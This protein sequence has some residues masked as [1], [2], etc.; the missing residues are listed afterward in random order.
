[1]QYFSMQYFGSRSPISFIS[2]PCPICMNGVIVEMP[3]MESLGCNFCNHIFMIEKENKSMLQVLRMVDTISTLRWIW[4]GERWENA[5]VARAQIAGWLSILGV[6]LV[7]IPTAITS[8][9]AYFFAPA[10]DVPLSW[11]PKFWAI[12]TFCGHLAVLL[13]FIFDYTKFPIAAY[14]RNFIRIIRPCP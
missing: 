10:P 4:N 9:A 1:M 8:L 13:S 14:W 3:M 5:D 2:A 12:A 11:F 6:L 7:I